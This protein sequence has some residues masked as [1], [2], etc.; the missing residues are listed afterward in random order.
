MSAAGQRLGKPVCLTYSGGWINGPGV[1]EAELDP[2]LQCFQSID[3]CYATLAAWH[4]REAR[5][6][7][8][9]SAKP[10]P[11]HRISSID[12][13]TD[14]SQRIKASLT[15]SIGERQSKS[16]LALYGIPVTEDCLTH[17]ADEAAIAAQGPDHPQF[18]V[19]QTG[20][21][22]AGPNDCCVTGKRW[23]GSTGVSSTPVLRS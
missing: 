16:I 4:K 14:A 1:T 8:E 2:N 3:R 22:P 12:A 11:H 19:F 20:R 9:Q 7:A 10:R 5:R 6:S 15:T 17:S 13:A 23:N 21:L 18:R